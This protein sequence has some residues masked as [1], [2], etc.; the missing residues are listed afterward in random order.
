MKSDDSEGL[1]YDRSIDEPVEMPAAEPAHTD[2]PKGL[3]KN[4]K[5]STEELSDGRGFRVTFM[6][7]DSIEGDN[8]FVYAT[9]A[10]LALIED[11]GAAW[12]WSNILNRPNWDRSGAPEGAEMVS[13]HA[14]LADRECLIK[15]APPQKEQA[16]GSRT[17]QYIREGETDKS[18]YLRRF[19]A[20][21][22]IMTALFNVRDDMG[23]FH[24]GHP[25]TEYFVGKDFAVEEYRE[26]INLL[27]IKSSIRELADDK[28]QGY[29]GLT[30]RQ[31]MHW[32]AQ[33]E[34]EIERL[35]DIF[36]MLGY[37]VGEPFN[38]VDLSAEHWLCDGLDVDTDRPVLTLLD[39]ATVAIDNESSVIDAGGTRSEAH[40]K[41]IA[42]RYE[43][44]PL[45][46]RLRPGSS[47]RRR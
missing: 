47:T 28:D 21:T 3:A 22:K 32:L 37:E 4:V 24:I 6:S 31:W 2:A 43:H 1:L 27:T 8:T 11:L 19:G 45:L 18:N 14:K 15:H 16:A 42:H 30:K 41:E 34:H 17:V 23:V 29:F 44:D 39:Q 46:M 33:F 20:T 5:L 9:E 40:Y 38:S 36:F 13:W 35:N 7:A 10:G 25:L 12:V 26:G